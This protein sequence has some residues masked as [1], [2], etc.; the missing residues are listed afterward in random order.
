MQIAAQSGLFNSIDSVTANKIPIGYGETT[1]NKSTEAVSFV[2]GNKIKSTAETMLSNSL[3]G[4]IAGLTVM[5]KGGEPGTTSA[6][7]YIRGRSTY[8]LNSAILVFVDGFESSF[9]HLLPQEIESIAILKDAAALAV[10]G[11]RGANGVMLVTTNRGKEE[12]LK[13]HVDMKYG[14]SN[15]LKMPSFLNAYQYANLYNEAISNDLGAWTTYYDNSELE[16]YKNQSN[17]YF[18]PDVN[19]TN[20]I[21]KPSTQFQEVAVTL[22]GGNKNAK[23]F[24]LVGLQNLPKL[25]NNNSNTSFNNLKKLGEYTKYNVRSNVDITINDIF[26]FQVNI[27]GAIINSSTPNA[28][29]FFSMINAL[30]PNAFPVRNNDDSWA[31]SSIYMDNP[32]ATLYE[33]GKKNYHTR[34]IQTDFNLMQNLDQFL[35]GL[36]LK[37]SVSFFGY[38]QNGYFINKDYERF[39]MEE[40]NGEV[41]TNK[42]GGSNPEFSINEGEST[43]SQMSR[44]SFTIQA[45]YNRTFEQHQMGATLGGMYSKYVVDGNEQPYLNA[46]MFGRVSYTYSE[47]YITQLSFAYNGSENLPKNEKYGFFPALSVGWVTSKEDFASEVQW[48]DFLKLRASGGMIGSSDLSS[49]RFGY[50]TYFIPTTGRFNLGSSANTSLIGLVEGRLGNPNITYE[51]NYKYNF[52]I[53]AILFSNFTLNA[54]LFYE[55]R[56]GILATRESS[57]P[58]VVAV[59]LPY[60]NIGIVNNK[61]FEI[62]LGYQRRI[63]DFYYSVNGI[64]SYAKS[65]IEYQAETVR[66]ED[67]LY[68]TGQPVGQYFGL[69]AVGLF[70]SWDEINDINTPIHTFAPVQ[71]G[72]IRY[73]DLNKDG[74]INEN[75]EVAIGFSRIP[76]ISASL[77]ITLGYKGFD[78]FSSFYGQA[79]RSVMLGGNTVWAFYNNGQAPTM[80][81]QRW[82]YYPSQNI[83]TRGSAVYPRLTA[84][85]NNNNYRVS[86]F[87]LRDASFV[88]LQH[89]ELGHSFQLNNLESLKSIR[90]YLQAANLFT[91]SKLKEFD[92]EVMS[93]YPMMK[94]FALGMNLQF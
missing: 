47:K 4:K 5:H 64:L 65:T 34:L 54:D 83:D 72:D 80:A 38:S 58:S 8:N 6:D 9:D 17:P 84:S 62:E 15:P 49:T 70:N 41:V 69:E 89:I 24:T 91:L 67:Y 56:T 30:P 50:Q 35:K 21:L 68:R 14:L 48:I 11:I 12:A 45:D 81:L 32:L 33:K 31:A 1:L 40:V 25:Y 79:N 92:P 55:K 42:I 71:P 46:G 57:V 2:H 73:K 16:F 85:D 66:P 78:L 23:Y 37:E 10:Y 3:S 28:D 29:N 63:A 13:I 44:T 77:N 75:D 82:S 52:G 36:S 76:Q 22:Q 53:D 7:L 86:N 93:G 27:G 19:W 59:L 18:Y 90:V 74:F 26:S 60:E 94:S 87:W 20:Q 43:R 51:K 88:R 39:Q 61:G